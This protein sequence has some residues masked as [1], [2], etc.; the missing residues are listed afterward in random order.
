MFVLTFSPLSEK[1]NTNMGRNHQ[2]VKK[3]TLG[4]IVNNHRLLFEVFHSVN[5]GWCFSLRASLVD[6]S[7]ARG[8]SANFEVAKI[9]A[10]YVAKEAA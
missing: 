2:Q 6:Q 9:A 4:K 3:S 10:K 7:A 1:V 5:K 8:A